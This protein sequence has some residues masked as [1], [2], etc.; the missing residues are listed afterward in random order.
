MT[1][2]YGALPQLPMARLGARAANCAALG[3]CR[4]AGGSTDAAHREYLG[5]DLHFRCVSE[6]IAPLQ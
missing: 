2:R 4:R 5:L 1:Q 6:R 3:H